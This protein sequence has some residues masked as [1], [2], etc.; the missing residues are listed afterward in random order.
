VKPR[1]VAI[2]IFLNL[3]SI[4]TPAAAQ[5]LDALDKAD[6]IRTERF[7]I[8]YS[9]KLADK[10][11]GL[12]AYADAVLL[13]MESILGIQA[14]WKRLPVLISDRS[15]FFSA[16]YTAYPSDRISINLV[17][18][19]AQG[20]LSSFDDE[21]KYVFIHELSHALT[22]GSASPL[23]STLSWL[24]GD[25]II[26]SAW[27]APKMLSEG[28]SVWMESMDWSRYGIYEENLPRSGEGR[29]PGRLHDPV[30][31]KDVYIDQ[32]LGLKRE[33]WEV[34]GLAEHPGSGGLPY[35]YGGLFV[36]YLVRR[37]GPESI[38]LLWRESSEGNLARGFDGTLLSKGVFEKV[39]SL[40]LKA[41]WKDFLSTLDSPGTA[42][43]GE[44]AQTD[45]K[46]LEVKLS[47][48]PVL[49]EGRIG[50]YTS[51]GDLLYFIDLE[52]RGLYSLVPRHKEAARRLL[53]VDS[54]VEDMQVLPGEKK[55]LLQWRRST[56]AGRLEAA[57]YIVDPADGKLSYQGTRDEASPG[58]AVKNIAEPGS[59]PLLYAPRIDETEGL[60]YGLIRMGTAIVPARVNAQGSMELLLTPLDAVSSMT[61]PEY[62]FPGARGKVFALQ[63]SLP[64]SPP[65]LAFLEEDT[66]AWKLWIQKN[67]S[68]GGAESPVFLNGGELVYL[69]QNGL[70]TQA[71]KLLAPDE[72]YLAANC[73]PIEAAWVS[74]QQYREN[75]GSVESQDLSSEFRILPNRLFPRIW[76]NSRY[77]YIDL[78]SLGLQF[79]GMDLTERV[80]WRSSAGWHFSAAM[81]EAS[82]AIQLVSNAQLFN[83]NAQD[84]YADQ[85]DSR[86]FARILG[87]G[88]RYDTAFHFLP[89]Q[90]RLTVSA[91][92]NAAGIDLLPSLAGYLAPVLAYSSLGGSVKLG[93]SD[94]YSLPFP[95]SDTQGIKAILGTEY[96]KLPGIAESVSLST[97]L[98]YSLGKPGLRL[99]VYGA[100]SLS[101]ALGFSASG[102]RFQSG[103]LI[104]PSALAAAYPSYEEY[105]A[106]SSHSPWYA[107]G[108]LAMRLF[109][110]EPWRCIGLVKMPWL[111][112]W[113]LGRLDMKGGLRAAA[114]ME[115]QLPAFPASAFLSL[116]IE[117]AIM[118]GLAAEGRLGLALEAAYAFDTKLSG[119]QA[120]FFGFAFGMR[121]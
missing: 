107:Y 87:S 86:P 73:E 111:P 110:F 24:L 28:T 88:L 15:P 63:V 58:D 26:P 76:E 42:D 89:Y 62:G 13:D 94:E 104:Y 11:V 65:R 83:F 17:D 72:E 84:Y 39:Y 22:L 23:W 59:I 47:I 80:S 53:A 64:A 112:T 44:S 102:R 46:T 90:R 115:N 38:G 25:Y 69:S 117:L 8:Y 3:L 61:G 106:L 31:L 100:V 32:S 114:L 45:G 79:E 6:H 121:I 54:L 37:F 18:A 16:Y 7:D 119:G 92:I 113:T 34:S 27:I 105:A 57:D 36:D 108:E 67:V 70:G 77:P 10:A 75:R 56:F 5:A 97:Y 29:I 66:G 20:E 85:G 81:P 52:R 120:L 118:A 91:A 78:D 30:A 19:G 55:L 49:F 95:P 60:I 116:D 35:L 41:V 82:L 103:G 51:L 109:S 93:Y 74:L 98:G 99:S 1:I 14:S 43:K 48:D 68:A 71:L 21:L 96:E 12:A 2:L 50:S 4:P 40:P 9:Q 33:P 101:E